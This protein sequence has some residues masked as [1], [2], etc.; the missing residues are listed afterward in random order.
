MRAASKSAGGVLIMASKTRAAMSRSPL[1]ERQMRV[2]SEGSG[3][4]LPERYI[5]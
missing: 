4:A 2:A 3:F 5:C 1:S